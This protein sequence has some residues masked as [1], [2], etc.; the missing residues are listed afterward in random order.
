MVDEDDDR[1]RPLDP[2][3]DLDR[4]LDDIVPV[5]FTSIVHKRLDDDPKPYTLESMK[6]EQVIV[7]ANGFEY[8][9]KLVGADEGEL[10]LRSETRWVVLP[11]AIVTSVKPR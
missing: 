5:G 7:R 1:D 11:L 8:R 4:D 10:Y 3:R 9:G 2:D 6:G